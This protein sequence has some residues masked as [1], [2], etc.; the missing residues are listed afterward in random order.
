MWSHSLKRDTAERE[1]SLQGLS[2]YQITNA[3]TRV[4]SFQI[5]AM[6]AA[7]KQEVDEI[8][9]LTTFAFTEVS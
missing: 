3:Y 8:N 2:F 1:F 5:T 4:A 9:Q 7:G 6:Q